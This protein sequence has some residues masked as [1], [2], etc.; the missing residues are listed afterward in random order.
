MKL[1]RFFKSLLLFAFFLV[2]FGAMAQAPVEPD[3]DLDDPSDP[4]NP[5]PIAN[6]ILPMLVVGIVTAYVLLRKKT[7]TQAS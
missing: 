5:A 2:S 6:Y 7:T 4:L 3:P 1:N